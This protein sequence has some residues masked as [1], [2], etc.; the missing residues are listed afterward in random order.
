MMSLVPSS[1]EELFSFL[2]G[3]GFSVC[4]KRRSEGFGDVVILLQRGLIDI[5]FVSDRGEWS[6]ELSGRGL[7]GDW[8]DIDIWEACLDSKRA[9]KE[10]SS[11]EQQAAALLARL[12]E[13]SAILAAT[14]AAAVASALQSLR[15]ERA[16]A[17][18]G[19]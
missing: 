16:R 5:R 7:G 13:I 1:L 19:L 6:V 11:L 4:E 3:E 12:S 15:A 18:L 14:D 9:S 2:V 8:F 17:R 10:P